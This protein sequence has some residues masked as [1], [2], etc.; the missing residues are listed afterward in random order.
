MMPDDRNVIDVEEWS[1]PIKPNPM[2]KTMRQFSLRE[3]LILEALF[4]APMR[5]EAAQVRGYTA[6]ELAALLDIPLNAIRW[7]LRDLAACRAIRHYGVYAY[8]DQ[9]KEKIW[10]AIL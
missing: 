7:R 9:R 1:K 2:P 6:K 10:E 5:K 3:D 8:V 4:T